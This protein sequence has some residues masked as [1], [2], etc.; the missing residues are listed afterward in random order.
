[1]F[2]FSFL[3]STPSP[4]HLPCSLLSVP[5]AIALLPLNI[6]PPLCSFLPSLTSPLSLPLP[7]QKVR[8]MRTSRESHD[9]FPEYSGSK[10]TSTLTSK[11]TTGNFSHHNIVSLNPHW[12]PIVLSLALFGICFEGLQN[13]WNHRHVCIHST[14]APSLSISLS[15][16]FTSSST[17]RKQYYSSL[18]CRIGLNLEP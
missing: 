11:P 8:D 17:R 14:S 16:S 10:K 1:M 9:S 15:P 2:F 4:S 5:L 6:P 12:Y 3:S 18:E 13:V 7:L